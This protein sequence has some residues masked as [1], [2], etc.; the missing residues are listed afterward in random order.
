MTVCVLQSQVQVEDEG[1]KW[2]HFDI[3]H[4]DVTDFIKAKREDGRLQAV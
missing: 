2:P 1:H 4:P 3:A